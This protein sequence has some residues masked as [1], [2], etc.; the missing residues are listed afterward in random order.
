ML[1]AFF[2]ASVIAAWIVGPQD[3]AAFDIS[4]SEVLAAHLSLSS[5]DAYPQGTDPLRSGNPHETDEVRVVIEGTDDAS[6]AVSV[7]PTHW[8]TVRTICQRSGIEFPEAAMAEFVRLRVALSRDNLGT[9]A[10]L[11]QAS[12]IQA[13]LVSGFRS[14]CNSHLK[15]WMFFAEIHHPVWGTRKLIG[16]PCALPASN[17]SR[18]EPQCRAFHNPENTAMTEYNLNRARSR[19]ILAL[20]CHSHRMAAHGPGACRRSQVSSVTP[21][22]RSSSLRTECVLVL[23]SS[24]MMRQ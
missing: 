6:C 1:T 18:S 11:L 10:R 7:N 14:N 23:G 9:L 20:A 22:A 24:T 5:E 12:G 16:L 3:S 19:P 2:L 21:S 8:Q 4:M 15:S 17:L 13:S